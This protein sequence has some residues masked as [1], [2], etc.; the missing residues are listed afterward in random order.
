M[1]E[2]EC[3]VKEFI[4]CLDAI[5]TNQSSQKSLPIVLRCF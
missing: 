2:C 5:F 3:D 4:L 1:V